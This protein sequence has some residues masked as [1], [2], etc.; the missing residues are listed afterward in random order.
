MNEFLASSQKG[1]TMDLY[2]KE[3]VKFSHYAPLTKEQKLSRFVLGLRDEL[4]NE[5]DTLRPTN[6]ADA[7]IR[8][9]A[10]LSSKAK[11]RTSAIKKPIGNYYG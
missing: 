8:A 10:K 2:Y 4:A 3:F 5:V 1:C 7:L 6:L 9:K 11:S